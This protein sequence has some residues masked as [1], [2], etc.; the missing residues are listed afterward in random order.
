MTWKISRISGFFCGSHEI[1]SLL[2][3]YAA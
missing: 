2:G 3:C 1:F